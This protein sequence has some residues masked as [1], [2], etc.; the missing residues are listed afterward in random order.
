MFPC[1]TWQAIERIEEMIHYLWRR[2][3]R[4]VLVILLQAG[5]EQYGFRLMCAGPCDVAS[6]CR[7]GWKSW[8]ILREGSP[9]RL[10][11]N[12]KAR[13]RPDNHRCDDEASTRVDS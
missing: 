13:G 3:Q 2:R 4:I 1:K 12:R 9:A 7:R 10:T 8:R 6:L 11:A 5:G